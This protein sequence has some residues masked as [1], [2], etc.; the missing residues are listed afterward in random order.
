LLAHIA[1]LVILG[2]IF[3]RAKGELEFL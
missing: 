3:L 2:M 1:S